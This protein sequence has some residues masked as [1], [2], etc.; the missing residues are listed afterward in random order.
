MRQNKFH[1]KTSKTLQND[2]EELE[3]LAKRQSRFGTLAVRSGSSK[4]TSD[5][6][7]EVL[8]KRQ[9]RFNET[10]S[11]VLISSEE[12]DKLEARRTRFSRAIL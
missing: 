9:K 2:V 10:I 12:K 11:S 6:D 7:V 3:K 5:S 4:P 8:R 1:E